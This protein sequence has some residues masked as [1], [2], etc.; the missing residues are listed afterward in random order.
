M[1]LR[2]QIIKRYGVDIPALADAAG[3][4]WEVATGE[5]YYYPTVI[6]LNPPWRL[7]S[8]HVIEGMFAE[9]IAWMLEQAAK[10]T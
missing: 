5:C 7:H 2:D 6:L 1:T 10:P 9:E 4:K 3:V 8:S